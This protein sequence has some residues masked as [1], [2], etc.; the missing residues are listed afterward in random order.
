MENPAYN[1]EEGQ[2]MANECLAARLLSGKDNTGGRGGPGTAVSTIYDPRAYGTTAAAAATNAAAVVTTPTPAAFQPTTRQQPGKRCT[3]WQ[4]P[5]D[6]PHLHKCNSPPRTMC[7]TNMFVLYTFLFFTAIICLTTSV[8]LYITRIQVPH[9]EKYP[10]VVEGEF[11]I[12]NIPYTIGFVDRNSTEFLAL[13]ANIT[14]QLDDTFRNSELSPWYD[15]CEVIDLSPGQA[16]GVQVQCEIKFSQEPESAIGIGQIGIAFL[17]TLR[18]QHGHTWL[19]NYSV[20][21]QSIGFQMSGE[22]GVWTDWSEWSGCEDPGDYVATRTRKC[23]TRDTREPTS[24][25][26]CLLIPGNKS[27][28]DLMPCR[29]YLSQNSDLDEYFTV[30]PPISTSTSKEVIEQAPT[31]KVAENVED[32][33]ICDE[34]KEDEVCLADRDEGILQCLPSLDTKDLTGCGGRCGI[35]TQYCQNIH[36]NAYTCVDTSPCSKNEF[37]C[38]NRMC[39]SDKAKCNGIYDC[40]DQTDEK[41]CPCDLDTH[42]RC[43]IQ[44]LLKTK[45]CDGVSDCWNGH[46]ELNCTHCEDGKFACNSNDECVSYDHFCDAY[47]DCTDKSDE[48]LGCEGPCRSNEKACRNGRCVKIHTLCDETEDCGNKSINKTNC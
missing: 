28:L 45:M 44:C 20:D 19:G 25:D 2:R 11:Q 46:D 5:S 1:P 26:R 3:C 13:S 40:L 15:G 4:P 10:L 7:H 32:N 34:C 38:G 29:I 12:T 9:K 21:V 42:F 33:W 37:E 30:P 36:R 27:D 35:N 22:L 47:A 23:L 39:V 16:K 48:P 8:L 43:G 14:T 17:K 31:N 24:V 6:I 41:D 18:I